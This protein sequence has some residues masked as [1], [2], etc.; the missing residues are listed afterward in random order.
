MS[1]ENF[2]SSQGVLENEDP[3]RCMQRGWNW[4]ACSSPYL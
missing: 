3:I 2:A 1:A 4:A